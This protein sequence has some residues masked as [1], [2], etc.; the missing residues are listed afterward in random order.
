MFFQFDFVIFVFDVLMVAAL[1]VVTLKEVIKIRI[2]KIKTKT[3]VKFI[4]LV[5]LTLNQ[6]SIAT[7]NQIR[8]ELGCSRGTAYYY[9]RAL[10]HLFPEN[11]P[12]R[13]T[14][15]QQNLNNY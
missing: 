13:N 5:N 6:R 10:R 8:E 2:G 14:D 9:R 12:P 15:V 1:F 7:I 4:I 3:L 11:F